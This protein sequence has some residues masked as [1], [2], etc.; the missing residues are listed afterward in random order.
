MTTN[1]KLAV[2]WDIYRVVRSLTERRF[3]VIRVFTLIMVE[4]DSY[5]TFNICDRK[6]CNIPGDS[7]LHTYTHVRNLI[8]YYESSSNLSK[9]PYNE[10]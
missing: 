9:K 6:W 3:T 2:I 10:S 8:Q 7:H 5:E 1:M 4:V